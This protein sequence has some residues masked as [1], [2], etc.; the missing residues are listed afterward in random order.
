MNTRFMK[1]L[2]VTWE[3]TT[4]YT[5]VGPLYQCETSSSTVCQLAYYLQASPQFSLG[6]FYFLVL[7]QANVSSYRNT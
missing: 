1:F 5:N 3:N 4:L 6:V 7:Q 2:E